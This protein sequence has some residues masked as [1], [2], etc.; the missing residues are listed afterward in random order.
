MTPLNRTYRAVGWAFL[1]AMEGRPPRGAVVALR[2]V[3]AG[4][5][6]LGFDLEFARFVVDA[7]RI[8]GPDEP[9]LRRLAEE[10][11]AIFT[12]VN[13]S[14]LLARLDEVLAVSGA[15]AATMAPLRTSSAE[16]AVP[17]TA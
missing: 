7:M 8:L 17:G 12:R 10:A 11:R 16:P 5:R 9:E 6:D 15:S 2:P 13:A 14:Q 3:I 4:L 1:A